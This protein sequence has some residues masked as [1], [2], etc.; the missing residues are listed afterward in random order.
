MHVDMGKGHRW[1]VQTIQINYCITCTLYCWV[2]VSNPSARIITTIPVHTKMLNSWCFK[3]ASFSDS[4]SMQAVQVN[5]SRLRVNEGAVQINPSCNIGIELISAKD[6]YSNTA[7][8]MHAFWESY[9]IL[10]FQTCVMRGLWC[11]AK[12]D[13]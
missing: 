8:I 13:N 7:S 5:L 10:S 3:D 1:K 2:V 12:R 6:L 4:I 11:W 9:N